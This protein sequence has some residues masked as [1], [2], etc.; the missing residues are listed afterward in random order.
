MEQRN[1]P[2]RDAQIEVITG[3]KERQEA[4][5]RRWLAVPGFKAALRRRDEQPKRKVAGR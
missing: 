5:A 2:S 3:A 4:V 1:K